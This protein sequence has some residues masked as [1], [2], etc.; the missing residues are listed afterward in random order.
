MPEPIEWYAG[1]Q[2]DDCVAAAHDVLDDFDTNFPEYSG[3]G[4]EIAGFVW[5]QGHK[6]AQNAVHA[7]RYELNMVNLIN[8]FRNEFNA[9]NA[10]FV[11]ASIGFG[12]WDM[13]MDSNYGTVHKAQMAIGDPEKHPEFAGNVFSFDAR[14]YWR[15]VAES[16]ANQ[17]HHYHRN[18]ET[19]LLVG[20]ALGRGMVQVLNSGGGDGGFIR[21]DSNRDGAVNIADGVY[22]L[23][24]LFAQGPPIFCPDA[25]DAND[26][27][28]VN[29]ADAIYILQNLFAQGPAIPP[30]TGACGPDPTSGAAGDLPPC[31]YPQNLCK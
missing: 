7:S 17:G 16:P 23:Q 4:Y 18:A 30:P 15:S 5:W 1:K 24:N 25:G 12:G 10:P 14:G 22:I 19:F 20:D 6:D 9:P 13:D 8:A 21:G 28:G 29:I 11:M 27:E 2:Y 26:D 3:Q 31:D